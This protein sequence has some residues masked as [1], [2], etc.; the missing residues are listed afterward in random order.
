MAV[1][2]AGVSAVQ[3]TISGSV[4]AGLVA[5]ATGQTVVMKA[6]GKGGQAVTAGTGVTLY[7]VTAL[8][9]FYVQSIFIQISAAYIFEIRD[10]G[11]SGTIKV[12]GG[13]GNNADQF[14]MTF[15]TPLKFTTDVWFDISANNTI[16]YTLVGYE[17]TA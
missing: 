15:P 4:T 12:S 10:G 1:G 17:V 8:K 3:A 16:W 7:T 14:Q 6:S 2:Y 13:S 11:S 5:P 9:N